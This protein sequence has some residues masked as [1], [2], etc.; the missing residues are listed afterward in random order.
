VEK[1]PLAAFIM[2]TMLEAKP[3]VAGMS[4]E[5]IEKKPFAIFRHD[6]IVLAI[7]GIGKANA[8]IATAFCCQRF[9]PAAVCNLGAAGAADF[10]HPLGGAF[11]VTKII[12][13]DRPELSSQRPTI[14]QPDVLDGFKTATLSTSDRAILDPEERRQVSRDAELMDMEG[15]SVAQACK[16][17]GTKCYVFK[18]VSDTPDHTEDKDI[19]KNIRQY[20]TPFYEFITRSVIRLILP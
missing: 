9:N 18:F 16:M 12:E 7:S 8:A 11:H 3:F 19:I 15:A 5:E 20:R 17:F 2:A 10:S 14:H 13:H 6:N 4:M 1:N